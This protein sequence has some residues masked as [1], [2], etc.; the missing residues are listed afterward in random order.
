VTQVPL[1][2]L[3]RAAALAA[4]LAL[5]APAAADSIRCAGGIV[6]T[7]DLKLD[8][9]AKCGPATL[10]DRVESRRSRVVTTG[11]GASALATAAV[12]SGATDGIETWTYDFGPGQLV[13]LVTLERGRV[14]R[15]ETAGYGYDAPPERAAIR[16]VRCDPDT[17]DAG[18]T[19]LELL[20]TCGEPT[21]REAWEELRGVASFSGGASES[22]SVTVTVELW[23]YDLGSNRFIRW[24]QL[25]GGRVVA[26]GTGG[27]GYGR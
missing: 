11:S 27:Y 22:A 21:M 2:K 6:S 23:T 26:E 8:L 14:T 15:V 16:A 3:A 12:L 25:E 19:R 10:V 20:A 24:F 1:P 9:L 4:A 18:D 7:G 13:R 17:V 5:A